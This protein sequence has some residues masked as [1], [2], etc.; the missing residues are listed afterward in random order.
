MIDIVGA[1]IGR[2]FWWTVIQKNIIRRGDLMTQ[3]GQVLTYPLRQTDTF[4]TK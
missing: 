3:K 4:R 1:T 2:L